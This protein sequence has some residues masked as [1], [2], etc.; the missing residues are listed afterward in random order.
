MTPLLERDLS[1]KRSRHY[2][3]RADHVNGAKGRM[4][5]WRDS[6]SRGKTQYWT[7]L[8]FVACDS[9]RQ[10]PGPHDE[11]VRQELSESQVAA[12]DVL[13]QKLGMY[14]V[15]T[16]LPGLTWQARTT[17]VDLAIIGLPFSSS[18]AIN[19]GQVGGGPLVCVKS[20]IAGLLALLLVAL[21]FSIT[22]LIIAQLTLGG[23]SGFGLDF[24]RG[25]TV[26]PLCWLL[27]AIAIFSAG[28]F[29]ELRRLTK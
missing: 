24:A 20:I 14:N 28:F 17:A 2:S 25:H 6:K 21:L 15:L 26:V 19:A 10:Q 23:I 16:Q 18:L 8:L 13:G 4:R 7:L 22:I 9:A 11:G 5:Y 27:A 29:W 12:M 1:I 3:S